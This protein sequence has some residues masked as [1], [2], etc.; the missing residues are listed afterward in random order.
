[1]APENGF[2]ICEGIDKTPCVQNAPTTAKSGSGSI[3]PWPADGLE[4]VPQCPVCGGKERELLHRGL[5]DRVFRCAPGEWNLHRCLSCG[6]GYLDPRPNRATIA[7]AYSRYFT[8]GSANAIEG[9]PRSAWRRYRTAQ[10]NAYLN[11]RY[12]YRL[13]PAA[14]Q[15]P[16]WLST[17]R[18]QRFDK[19]VDYLPYPGEGAR[20]LDVGC[21][22]GAFLLQMRSAGWEVHG[23]EPDPKAAAAAAGAGLDV[24]QGLLETTTHQAGYY[25]AITL[26]H[27]IEHLHDP[28]STLKLG[29]RALK[30]GGKVFVATPN[31]AARGHDF[32]GPDYFPLD[33]PRH[34]ILFTPDSLRRAMKSAGLVPDA[35][36]QPRFTAKEM[37][38]RSM[39]VR[40]GSDPMAFKP[41]LSLADRWKLLSLVR[42]ANRATRQQLEL[43][44]E[45]VLL[46]SKP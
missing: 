45:L 18:R 39:H 10:R 41:G 14:A 35:E 5:T 40:R 13:S 44:E 19:F 32:F 33:P 38:L 8:H 30:P 4:P 20:V 15:P 22:N 9:V 17:D 23:V 37:L 42:E 11:A 24:K 7:L 36:V 31:F 34:L 43:T 29:W 16:R 25:D 12:G 26:N 21:G 3:E 6:T 1:M 27:V 46:A 28:V 2:D